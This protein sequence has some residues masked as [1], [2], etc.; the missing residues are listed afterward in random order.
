MDVQASGG[1]KVGA[2]TWANV[3][4]AALYIE[5]AFS[6]LGSCLVDINIQD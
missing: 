3:V 2:S 4:G 5:A 1:G 6:A